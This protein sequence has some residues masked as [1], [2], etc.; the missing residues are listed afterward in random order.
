MS[1]GLPSNTIRAMAQDKDGFIWLAG[2]SGLCRFDGYKFISFNHFGDYPDTPQHIGLMRIISQDLLWLS[3]ST[4][5][6]GCYDLRA[7]RFIPFESNG[8][9]LTGYSKRFYTS[10]G[11]WLYD[12]IN[13]VCHPYVRFG[14]PVIEFFN[15]RNRMLS[16]DMV[17]DMAEDSLGQIWAATQ[18]G[19]CRLR[20][21]SKSVTLLKGHHVLSCQV[22]EGQ[23]IAFSQTDQSCY[24]FL[25][26]GKLKS[27][28]H[29][30]ISM[31]WVDK[32][33]NSIVWQHQVL[34]FT[35]QGMYSFDPFNQDFAC[36]SGLQISQGYLQGASQGYQMIGNRQGQVFVYP[37][38]GK[39]VH[40][41]LSKNLLSTN[42]KNKIFSLAIYHNKLYIACYGMG[43]YVY[44]LLT[45]HLQHFTA[46]DP[47]PLFHSN[48]LLDVM[49]DRSGCIWVS[50]ESAGLSC[51]QPLDDLEATYYYISPTSQGDWTN[52]VRYVYFDKFGRL[53]TSTKDFR[54]HRF[55]LLQGS[56]SPAGSTRAGLYGYMVDSEGHVWLSTRGD[57]LYVDQSHFVKGKDG[58]QTSDFYTTVEDSHHRVWI[59]S[60]GDGLLMTHWQNGRLAPFKKF[61]CTALN[62]RKVHDLKI[63]PDGLLYVATYNGLYVVDTKKK[64]I[65]DRDFHVYNTL[66]GN[67]PND[68]LRCLTY[69]RGH[70]W[71]GVMATGVV[72]CD[73][74]KGPDRMT[75]T[76]LN[77]QNGLADNEVRSLMPDRFGSVWAGC[78]SGLSRIDVKENRVTTYRLASTT[79]GNTFAENSALAL[80]DGRLLFGTEDGLLAVNPRSFHPLDKRP[81]RVSITDLA[82]DGISLYEGVD[83]TVLD[84]ALQYTRSISLSH[85]HHALTFY[86]SNLNYRNLHSQLYQ[87]RLEGVDRGWSRATTVNSSTYANLSPGTYR[88]HVRAYSGTAWGPETVLKISIRQPWFNTWW[89]WMIYICLVGALAWYIFRS[90]RERFHM[91]QQMEIEKQLNEFRLN[92]FTQIAHEF[93]TPLA[94]IQSGVYHL[95]DP[96]SKYVSKTSLQTIKRGTNRLLRMVN[97][98]MEFRRVTTDN[99]KLQ[100][101]RGD[102]VVFVRDVWQDLWSA[103]EQKEIHYTFTPFA[104]HFQSLF[105]A[106]VVETVVYNLLS[107]A[108]KYVG[109]GGCVLLRI[110]HDR[111]QIHF[112]VED[113]GPG[114]SAERQKRLFQPFMHGYVSR[115]GMGIGLYTAHELALTHHGSLTYERLSESGGSRFTF[116]IP[117]NDD[118]YSDEE[119]QTG[120]ME[121]AMDIGERHEPKVL[122]HLTDEVALNS[123]TVAIIE[124]DPDM[125]EQMKAIVGY[126]FRTV[127]FVNG[128]EGYEGVMKLHPDL[129]LCDVML[130]D[131]EGFEIVSRVKANESMADTPVIMLTALDDEQHQLKAYQAGADD[132]MVKPCNYKLLVGRMI[133][134]VKWRQSRR[135]Q[136]AASSLEPSGTDEQPPQGT[137]EVVI[138]SRVDKNFK[139]NVQKLVADNLSNPQLSV[140]LLAEQM[141]M[142]RTKFYGK[143][144]ELFGI[145]PNKL[146]LNARMERA[147]ELILEGRL[148]ITEISFRVGMENPS[149]FNKCF[150]AHFGVSP[151]K[152]K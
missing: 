140:D 93:R 132:Y 139:S 145:S 103:A 110:T 62:S 147:A 91:H 114:I 59:A 11:V 97:Q 138:A 137:R 88:F 35:P 56:F 12:A 21:E 72:K 69:Y 40:L 27:K 141:S 143:M 7:G 126:Y 20:S 120:V 100:V 52:F 76:V 135:A 30:P 101:S 92:F 77:Q 109:T 4:Y 99:Q 113:D 134:L 36:P 13:G 148:S 3:T 131:M 1:N 96:S 49:V 108:V 15:R 8:K 118:A 58:M 66:S 124:D 127:G 151:S 33:N 89:A 14:R 64:N 125:M 116:S 75:Y 22:I 87:V 70:L 106:S 34:Y 136:A 122:P 133:Q 19:L 42:E 144:K 102:L 46:Q 31:G 44:D 71:A 73:F 146:I 48:Y 115:G 23:I 47:S 117:D 121:N 84:S 98:L 50:A 104:H 152:Y 94:I 24:T 16:S 74:T 90:T 41:D 10:H 83:S 107:N 37:P 60:W 51:I 57:G 119:C 5:S 82:I 130:P 149:Y 18:N 17:Y 111:G 79:L 63:G 43:L 26:N 85:N 129:I 142:G 32:I 81:A 29:L 128:K 39:V 28:V 68:E 54:L 80:P 123:Q 6:Y 78:A 53:M 150:K 45:G 38:K 2:T 86:Y 105:D 67:F 61:L 25:P 55:N 65:R 112:I 95:Q 9:A